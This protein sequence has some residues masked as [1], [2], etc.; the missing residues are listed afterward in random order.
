M[1]ITYTTGHAILDLA[2][3]LVVETC[4]N[5]DGEPRPLSTV[6]VHFQTKFVPLNGVGLIKGLLVY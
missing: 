5:S 2:Y 6:K 1:F 3:S 4:L